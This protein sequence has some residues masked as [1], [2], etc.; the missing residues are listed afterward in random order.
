MWDR[1]K[2]WARCLVD[3][4]WHTVGSGLFGQ[5]QWALLS[6]PWQPAFRCGPHTSHNWGPKPQGGEPGSWAWSSPQQPSLALPATLGALLT[7]QDQSWGGDPCQQ[8]AEFLTRTR[9]QLC[10]PEALRRLLR[11]GQKSS[12]A[13]GTLDLIPQLHFHNQTAGHLRGLPIPLRRRRR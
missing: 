3:W 9:Y 12:P 7:K 10:P 1:G 4:L 13:L 6:L 11:L 2:G 8:G 5:V